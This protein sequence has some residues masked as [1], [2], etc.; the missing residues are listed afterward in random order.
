MTKHWKLYV[1]GLVMAL[2]ASAQCYAYCDSSIQMAGA[3]PMAGH[4]ERHASHHGKANK[5]CVHQHDELFSPERGAGIVALNPVQSVLPAAAISLP[6][7]HNRSH[8]VLWNAPTSP[9]GTKLYLS[10]SA[11]RI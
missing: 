10:G 2:I 7:I 9:P 6:A 5:T 4:C 11:L 1:V 3:A 8:R